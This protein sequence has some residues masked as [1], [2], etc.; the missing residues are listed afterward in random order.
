MFFEQAIECNYTTEF[1]IEVEEI[2][3]NEDDVLPYVLDYACGA[4]HFL[5]ESM[6]EIQK[7]LRNDID[8]N[9]AKKPTVKQNLEIWKKTDYMWVKEYIYGIDFDHRLTKTTKINCFMNG[10]GEANIICADGLSPNSRS[11]CSK[12]MYSGDE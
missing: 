10:D 4:G 9:K 1:Y 11:L 7:I 2:K 6:E 3:T 5:T 12:P 8:P